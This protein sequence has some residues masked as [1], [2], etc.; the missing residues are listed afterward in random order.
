MAK[1]LTDQLLFFIFSCRLSDKKLMR[2]V[3]PR[4]D[5]AGRKIQALIEQGYITQ[6]EIKNVRK[7]KYL[8]LTKKGEEYIMENF[9]IEKGVMS[10]FNKRISGSERKGR[11]LKV[12]TVVQ[13]LYKYFPEYVN[14]YLDFENRLAKKE[15]IDLREEIEKRRK[16]NQYG[17]YFITTRELRDIDEYGL[18]K[19]TSVRA[20]GIM[21][22]NGV[23]YALYNHNHRRMKMSGDSEEKF[24]NYIYMRTGSDKVSAIHFGRSFKVAIDTMKSDSVW[25]RGEYIITCGIF[26]NNYFVP[27]TS[28]GAEQMLLYT[29]PNFRTRVRESLL[30]PEEIKKAHNQIYDGVS[31]DGRLIYLGFE[32][33]LTE[34]ERL[35]NHIYEAL[36]EPIIMYCLPHQKEFYKKVFGEET[37]I[38]TLSVNDICIALK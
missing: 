21:E 18:R 22:M 2:L 31:E 36:D 19:V 23:T 4:Y 17:E 9:H 25:S 14:E 38:R 35:G 10:K 37:E 33:N 7:E 27:M 5:Y 28:P 16:K 30:L 13:M 3:G 15:K 29:I 11:Q 24:S 6:G 32:C 12:A 8:M 1:Q 20:Q 34:L 26:D